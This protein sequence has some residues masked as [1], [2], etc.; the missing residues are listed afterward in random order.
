[1]PESIRKHRNLAICLIFFQIL[2]CLASIPFYLRRRSRLILISLISAFILTLIGLFGM[3][4]VKVIPILMH[5]TLTTAILGPFYLLIVL[6]IFVFE[7]QTPTHSINDQ[8][9]LFLLSLPEFCIFVIGVYCL[10]I[11]SLIYN[12]IKLRGE[13]KKHLP[14]FLIQGNVK[15]E[16]ELDLPSNSVDIAGGG[17]KRFDLRQG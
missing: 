13:E 6:S 3:I 16:I 5:S 4:R 15:K 10:Y 7:K 1:M 8:I 11:S 9:M 14:G 12:E 2:C 17:E